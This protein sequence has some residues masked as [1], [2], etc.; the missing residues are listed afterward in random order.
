MKIKYFLCSFLMLLIFSSIGYAGNFSTGLGYPYLSIK[1]DFPV[2]STEGR[3]VIGSGIKVY[4]VRGYWNYYDND[5]LKGFAGL[6]GGYIIFN[7]LDTKGTG[8]ERALFIG[9]EY[10][11]NKKLSLLIDLMPTLI[12]LKH[13][14][15]SRVRVHN[16]ELVANIGVYLHFGAK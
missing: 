4:S 10:F 6:E 13:A 15:D 1:Y 8:Y 5:K 11:I 12:S 16:F 9:G 3:L 2:I 14:D 7:T